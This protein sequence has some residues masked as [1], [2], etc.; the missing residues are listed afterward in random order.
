MGFSIKCD[1]CGN[2]LIVNDEKE[3]LSNKT[4]D[5]LANEHLEKH[6]TLEFFCNNEECNNYALIYI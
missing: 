1:K 5:L 6:T 3:Y 2:E 4:V